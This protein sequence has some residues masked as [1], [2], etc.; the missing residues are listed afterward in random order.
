MK[1]NLKL[2]THKA[3][4]GGCGH[5]RIEQPSKVLLNNNYIDE[6]IS[7][8]YYLNNFT[9]NNIT[10]YRVILQR[11]LTQQQLISL[12]RYKN[13]KLEILLDIDDLLWNLPDSNP[14]KNQFNDKTLTT[15]KQILYLVDK[16]IVSTVPLYDEIQKFVGR[17]SEI[18]PN[19]IS[20]NFFKNPQK[21]TNEKLRVIWAGSHTH[22]EDLFQIEDVVI[23]TKNLFEWIFMGYIPDR[24][25][26]F[27]KQVQPVKV[28]EYLTKLSLLNSDV[29]LIPLAKNDFNICKSNLKLIEFSALGV[30][31]ITSEIYPYKDNPAIK[32]PIT[33]NNTDMWIDSLKN[34]DKN[35]AIRFHH[36]NLCYNYAKQFML[37]N[38]INIS[39]IKK[40]WLD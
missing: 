38:K 9:I 32:I 40:I 3:D 35:E 6:I 14:V 8:T 22:K 30:P 24:L 21:R 29:A 23:K 33:K 5:Y 39:T 26:S 16:I 13:E 28:N 31:C 1:K 12:T 36:A 20:K 11:Q 37:E 27:V 18:L 4:F 17:N 19:M 25:K 34:Y 10:P 15:L 2:V 7:Q